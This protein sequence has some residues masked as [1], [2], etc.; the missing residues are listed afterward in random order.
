MPATQEPPVI[1]H[2]R[3]CA[4]E[5]RSATIIG[6][7]VTKALGVRGEKLA[8]HPDG[9]AIYTLTA[10]QCQRAIEK[11]DEAWAAVGVAA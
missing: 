8:D 1:R 7:G 3:T 6:V 2:L 4:A 9:G 11:W 10:K 5:G